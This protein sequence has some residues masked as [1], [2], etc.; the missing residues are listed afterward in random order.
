M[1]L[2]S[3]VLSY[4]LIWS[5]LVSLTIIV[6]GTVEYLVTG[7]SGYVNLSLTQLL[8]AGGLSTTAFPHYIYTIITGMLEFKS[9]A[10]IQ[11]GVLLLILSPI[12]RIFLQ[13]LI[14][15]KERDRSFTVIAAVV[16]LILLASLYLSK[17]IS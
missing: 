9:F 6:I 8:K 17:F 4:Y 12:G 11:F 16:F 13:I 1:N 14:Y 15:A 2:S 3:R 7:S 10:I 5:V